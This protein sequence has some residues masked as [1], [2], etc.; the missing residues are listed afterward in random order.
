MSEVVRHYDKVNFKTTLPMRPFKTK[1]LEGMTILLR[2]SNQP[3]PTVVS[4]TDRAIRQQEFARISQQPS[5][6][7]SG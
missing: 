2:L 7:A 5:C 1:W 3:L 4:L 6:P